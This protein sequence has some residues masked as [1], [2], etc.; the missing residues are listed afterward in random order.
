MS[1][2]DT[3][4]ILALKN[5][6]KSLHDN[7]PPS[8]RDK[9]KLVLSRNESALLFLKK[10]QG[11]EVVLLDGYTLNVEDEFACEDVPFE[12]DGKIKKKKHKKQANI[13]RSYLVMNRVIKAN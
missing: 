11:E 2:T 9:F 12:I 7:L 5:R 1:A 13:I 4:P 6:V 3:E 10:I 8:D